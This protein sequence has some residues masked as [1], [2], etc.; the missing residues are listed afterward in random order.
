MIGQLSDVSPGAPARPGFRL[1]QWLTPD[2]V[3][4][5][6]G[7]VQPAQICFQPHGCF[8]E[9]QKLGQ[10]T[11]GIYAH[12]LVRDRMEFPVQG[13]ALGADQAIWVGCPRD[14]R[15][16]QLEEKRIALML[17]RRSLSEPVLQ[18]RLALGRDGIDALFRSGILFDRLLCHKA[19]L[20]QARQGRVYLSGLHVPILFAAG[21]SRERRPQIISMTRALR[22]QSQES[23]TDGQAA[24]R[25][26][27][28]FRMFRRLLDENNYKTSY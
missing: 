15:K 10:L 12:P 9:Q 7:H 19:A 27:F 5:G 20:F 24:P 23:M 26:R 4:T 11:F 6:F 1:R 13:G 18:G 22:Q 28:V 25:I 14:Q 8:V 3:E 16:H 21:N 2:I 17:L